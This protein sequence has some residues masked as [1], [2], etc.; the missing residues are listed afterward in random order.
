MAVKRRRVLFFAPTQLDSPTLN[1]VGEFVAPPGI[2]RE[3]AANLW[4]VFDDEALTFTL[5]H[6]Y[7]DFLPQI[8]WVVDDDGRLFDVVGV[9]ETKPLVLTVKEVVTHG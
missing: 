1:P 4:A 6:A 5:E 8:G 9:S 3:P 2:T 7:P